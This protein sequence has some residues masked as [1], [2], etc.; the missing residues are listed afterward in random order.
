MKDEVGRDREEEKKENDEGNRQRGMWGKDEGRWKHAALFLSSPCC[1][2]SSFR[3]RE[4]HKSRQEDN[5]NN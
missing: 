2:F 1:T 3:R 5:N 4:Q